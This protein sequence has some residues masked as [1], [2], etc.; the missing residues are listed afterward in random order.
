[1]RDKYIVLRQ[2]FGGF[3]VVDS[4][5]GKGFDKI[6]AEKRA[7]KRQKNAPDLKYFIVKVVAETLTPVDRWIYRYE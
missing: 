3:S 4:N 5:S 1:M 7:I 2:N 6:M